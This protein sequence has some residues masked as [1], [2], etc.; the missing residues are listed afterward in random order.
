MSTSHTST[1][2]GT[3]PH[4]T[5][6]DAVEDG[7]DERRHRGGGQEERAD[8]PA[9]RAATR[10]AT[11]DDL[12]ALNVRIGT[13]RAARPN[14]RARVPA[15]VLEIDFGPLGV[16]TSSAQITDRY[17]P[18]SLVGRRVVCALG[19]APKRIA[20]VVSTCLVL[21]AVPGDGTGVVLLAVDAPVPDG[22]RVA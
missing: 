1:R 17:T 6:T 12:D 8:D 21:G 13:V 14:A 3:P 9:P 16:R 10:T 18:D 20:G 22:T 19:L 11:V 15:L 2:G 5:D 7:Q 4:E